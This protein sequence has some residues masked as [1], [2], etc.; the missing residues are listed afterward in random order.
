MR[1]CSDMNMLLSYVC[2]SPTV[3][4]TLTHDTRMLWTCVLLLRYIHSF[5]HLLLHRSASEMTYI[6]SGGALN[7]TLLLF[8]LLLHRK[9]STHYDT[10]KLT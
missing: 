1:D 2:K 8:F 5:I 6:V 9:G 4:I 7:S 10:S 3:Y